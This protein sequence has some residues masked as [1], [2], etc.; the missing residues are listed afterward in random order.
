MVNYDELPLFPLH[1][2]LY[3]DMPLPLHIFEAR[4]REMILQCRATNSPFGVVLMQNRLE[5]SGHAVPHEVGTTAQITQFEEMADGHMNIVVTGETRFR[6]M[7]INSGKAYLT[8]KVMPIAERE[9]EV[10]IADWELDHI[11]DLFKTYLISLLALSNRRLS[12]L[13]L[14]QEPAMLSYAIAS[15]L[16]VPLNEKQQLLEIIATDSR[17]QREVDILCQ[18]IEVQDSLRALDPHIAAKNGRVISP[19][20]TIELS[21]LCSL[22]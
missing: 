21:K 10:P 19:I 6:I 17:L 4:Y 9:P 15:V 2:V 12:A 18:E 5:S 11:T 20:D 22:N 8:A 16:Q 7:E 3:P 13:Q 1:V 14:P